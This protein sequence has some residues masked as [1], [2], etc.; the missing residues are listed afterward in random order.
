MAMVKLILLLVI[1]G[2]CAL[3]VAASRDGWTLAQKNRETLTQ[4]KPQQIN[5]LKPDDITLD[6]HPDKMILTAKEVHQALV[7]GLSKQEERRFVFLMQNRTGR[8]YKDKPLTPIEILGIN[9]RFPQERT[10]Y[11][12]I[13]ARQAFEKETKLLAFNSTYSHAALALKKTLHL[14]YLRPFNT[15]K[16]APL[17]YQPVQLKAFD[18]LLLFIHLHDSVKPILGSVFKSL[19][20]LPSLQINLYF[21]GKT[22]TRKAINHWAR[23]QTIDLALVDKGV[24]TLN[25]GNER[26]NA[27]K[28]KHKT[29][30]LLLVRDGKTQIINTGRF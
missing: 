13:A 12:S 21:V 10:H 27:L 23:A 24:V 29:P 25:F 8:Y 9:A 16:F 6:Q 1:S 28:E 2:H 26:F 18:T 15:E 7:W 4:E 22:V 20:L 5:L 30:L 11:A 19:G 17:H 3:I 14:P